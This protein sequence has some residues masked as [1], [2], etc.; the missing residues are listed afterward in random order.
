MNRVSILLFS[1]IVAMSQTYFVGAAKEEVVEKDAS[2]NI[3]INETLR[4]LKDVLLGNKEIT[5]KDE[6]LL[7]SQLG[8]LLNAYVR[9]ASE[10][11]KQGITAEDYYVQMKISGKI[12]KQYE[13]FK[14]LREETAKKLGPI[15]WPESFSY[16]GNIA[17]DQ[18]LRF[19]NLTPSF[20]DG[21]SNA[22][23]S[24]S[25]IVNLFYSSGGLAEL[26]APQSLDQKTLE[27]ILVKIIEK[28]NYS[29]EFFEK[30]IEKE[31]EK[32]LGSNYEEEAK[33][34]TNLIVHMEEFGIN[35]HQANT[36]LK[37]AK[38]ITMIAL[39]SSPIR[40]GDWWASTGIQGALQIHDVVENAA[41][42]EGRETDEKETRKNT[43]QP[44]V[45]PRRLKY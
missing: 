12:P 5:E 31:N 23:S 6:K 10:A 15:L 36:D 24:I 28:T 44:T 38:N 43:S 1:F 22:I 25:A 11:D 3:E 27:G 37:R 9:Y 16:G 40:K 45:I 39:A 13:E 21:Y 2:K 35:S 29:Y 14:N 4:K 19:I 42:S 30:K 7:V 26:Y 34:Y 33:K 18:F 17:E 20:K 32:I 41:M 8:S